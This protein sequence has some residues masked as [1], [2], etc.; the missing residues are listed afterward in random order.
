L[1]GDLGGVAGLFAG[2]V[3][4]VLGGGEFGEARFDLD[5][6]VGDRLGLGGAFGFGGERVDRGL[7][8]V[9]FACAGDEVADPRLLF[10]GECLAVLGAEDDGAGAARGGGNGVLE[11]FGDG[12]GGGVRDGDRG[13]ER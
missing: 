13:G 8:I 2:E 7:D 6:A 9:D 10:R 3:E 12:L 5:A 1:G 4:L 11:L